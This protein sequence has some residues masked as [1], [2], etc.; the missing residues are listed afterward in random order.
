MNHVSGLQNLRS[1]NALHFANLDYSVHI[2][3][4][5]EKKTSQHQLDCRRMIQTHN[6]VADRIRQTTGIVQM[7]TFKSDIRCTR[8]VSHFQFR[9]L[10]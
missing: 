4:N 7:L 5:K 1:Y 2:E 3:F 8:T 10:I 6:Q 9:I